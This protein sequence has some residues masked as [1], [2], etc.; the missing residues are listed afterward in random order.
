MTIGNFNITPAA[1][2]QGIGGL[3]DTYRQN[4]QQ[5][6]QKQALAQRQELVKR[7]F[8]GDD[9]AFSE[10][11]AANPNMAQAIQQ[12]IFQRAQAKDAATQKATL[13]SNQQFIRDYYA[14]APE[15]REAFLLEA[16]QNPEFSTISLD[17]EI[18][19]AAPQQRDALA[20]MFAYGVLG[21]EQAE[22][23]ISEPADVKVGRFRYEQTPTGFVK[24]DTATGQAQEVRIGS[25]EEAVAKKAEEDKLKQELEAEG[26]T[27]SR[28]EKLRSRYDKLSGD[29]IKVRDAYDRVQATE[30]T[31]AGDIALIF[32]YMKMLDPG[33]VVR[34]SEF[35]TA[36]NAAG[37]PDRIVNQYNRL[38][39]G[40]RLSP[41]QRK[42]FE[43]QAN[44]L[45]K[46]AR[47]SNSVLRDE[48]LR[49]GTQFGV[50]ESDIFGAPSD[51]VNWSDL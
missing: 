15:E 28:A 33:S 23:L 4:Q 13:E 34:E 27:F 35:A 43:S 7:A 44:A 39:S 14:R 6:Q 3:V 1:G 19:Q 42:S 24:F 40:E 47:E 46:K 16:S 48:T 2:F 12:T 36:Q 41:R 26:E 20:K 21:N 38:L 17:D 32:N 31:A 29:F 37:V 25:K 11:F 30:D 9:D 49:L 5:E 51:V 8:G 18:L 50:T 22:I 10:L 45:F